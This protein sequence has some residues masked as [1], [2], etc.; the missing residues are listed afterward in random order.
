MSMKLPL[1]MDEDEV[2]E[3]SLVNLVDKFGEHTMKIFTALL[4]EKRIFFLGYQRP[5]GYV[6]ES[7]TIDT[8]FNG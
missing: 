6:S 3:A 4:S 1:V 7:H 8:S 2:G 5:A